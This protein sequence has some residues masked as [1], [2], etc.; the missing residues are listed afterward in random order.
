VLLLFVVAALSRTALMAVNVGCATAILVYTPDKWVGAI[1]NALPA[2]GALWTLEPSTL[3][4]S[5]GSLIPW[6]PILLAPLGLH[7]AFF[8]LE[9]VAFRWSRAVQAGFIGGRRA[10]DKGAL[11]VSTRFLFAQGLKTVLLGSSKLT[12]A[13]TKLEPFINILLFF[14]LRFALLGVYNLC[15]AS[16]GAWVLFVRENTIALEVIMAIL[17]GASL[18]L[19]ASAPHALAGA[20]VQGAPALAAIAALRG[21]L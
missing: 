3:G 20:I 9:S 14:W 18:V 17:V 1:V 11:V 7:V 19:V 16:A 10:K 15:L 4:R 2:A 21:L 5:V 13:L 6:N 8:C 12:F